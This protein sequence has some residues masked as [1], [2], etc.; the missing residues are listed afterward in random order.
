MKSKHYL[1]GYLGLATV[2][3]VIGFLFRGGYEFPVAVRDTYFDIAMVNFL[4]LGILPFFVPPTRFAKFA[5]VF[6]LGWSVIGL[7]VLFVTTDASATD[8]TNYLWG[9]IKWVMG[10]F[11]WVAGPA[12]FV[13]FFFFWVDFTIAN[14]NTSLLQKIQLRWREMERHQEF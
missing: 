6:L 7:L 5:V 11:L 13:R 8:I 2:F 12:F 10:A 3:Y 1:V 4:M 14:P 9:K